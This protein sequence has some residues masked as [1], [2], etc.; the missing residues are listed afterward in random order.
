M[1][2]MTTRESALND[3]QMMEKSR[4]DNKHLK[5]IVQFLVQSQ[6]QWLK[7]RDDVSVSRKTESCK[8]AEIE[9]MKMNVSCIK[10]T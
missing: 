7:S 8:N 10:T 6:Q 2:R 4:D 9:A 3:Q 5:C 1:D